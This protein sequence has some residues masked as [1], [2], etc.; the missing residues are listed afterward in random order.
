MFIIGSHV[1][2]M[3]LFKGG[4]LLFV[5]LFKDVC[6]Y[7]EP[8]LLFKGRLLLFTLFVTIHDISISEPWYAPFTA[9]LLFMSTLL[10]VLLL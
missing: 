9:L 3:Q 8:V 6:Y 7:L 2:A 5:L 1:G 10:G 4:V